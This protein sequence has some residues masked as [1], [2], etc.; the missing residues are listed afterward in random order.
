VGR[1]LD[2]P[3]WV[4]RHADCDVVTVLDPAVRD[5]VEGVTVH[6]ARGPADPAVVAVADAL[7]SARGVALTLAYPT[8]GDEDARGDLAAYHRG[9]ARLCA[10]PVRAGF[11][12]ADGGGDARAGEG[13]GAGG[14]AGDLIVVADRHRGGAG[15]PGVVVSPRPTG[16]RRA[17]LRRLL[18][19]VAY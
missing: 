13:P 3:E 10:A 8:P 14:A 1:V 7:A 16:R 18:E 4:A 11:A 19:Q 17:G 6:V 12:R 15:S 9:L 2:R 5:A